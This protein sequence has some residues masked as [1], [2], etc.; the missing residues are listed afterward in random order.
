[1]ESK[2]KKTYKRDLMP[3]L[4]DLVLKNAPKITNNMAKKEN[5]LQAER[6]K[7]FNVYTKDIVT[8]ETVNQDKLLV[9]GCQHQLGE[10]DFA[11]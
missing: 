9:V 1:M 6:M 10:E 11:F 4:K 3:K 2:Q 7:S 8:S 5:L